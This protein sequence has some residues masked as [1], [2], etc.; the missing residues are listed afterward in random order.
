MCHGCGKKIG[1]EQELVFRHKFQ[2][3]F[4]DK[5]ETT[6]QYWGKV[7]CLKAIENR[8]HRSKF[9]RT[10][11]KYENGDEDPRIEAM[12]RELQ[13]YWNSQSAKGL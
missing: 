13:T 9:I 4:H 11:L 8:E 6:Y 3:S 10:K 7:D 5:Y 1:P 12:K 2:R